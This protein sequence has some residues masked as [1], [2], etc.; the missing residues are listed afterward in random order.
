MH[1]LF[2]P[3]GEV[4]CVNRFYRDLQSQNYILK[5]ENSDGEKKNQYIKGGLRLAPFGVVDYVFPKEYKN[6]VL[7]SLGFHNENPY[8][9]GKVRLALLRNFLKCKKPGKFETEM[10]YIWYKENVSLIPLG[11]RE[12]PDIVGM[13]EDD[14]GYTHEAL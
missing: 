1:A 9:L 7:T 14:K 8:K 4:D 2:I 6:E 11:I 13:H 10:Q 12:D 3:Y 5:M